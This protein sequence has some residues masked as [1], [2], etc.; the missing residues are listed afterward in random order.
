MR[1]VVISHV[2][3][4]PI[5]V[6]AERVG[7]AG[8]T[9]SLCYPFQGDPLPD[10]DSVSAVIVLGGAQSAY[11]LDRHP[12]LRDE[13]A[14]LAQAH[15]RQTPV[16]GICLGSQLL[17][18]AL[19]GR[20]L[21][22]IS[23]LEFGAISVD[24]TSEDN[25]PPGG[26]YYSFHSDTAQLPEDAEVLSVSDSYVQAW[27]S[28]SSSAIQFHPEIDFD[29]YDEILASEADKLERSGVDVAA[30]RSELAG[31]KQPSRHLSS[32]L[33]DT[34]LASLPSEPSRPA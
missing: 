15:E 21:P 28:G 13:I 31:P 3:A 5:P 25:W 8:H 20:A 19:G 9:I 17:A 18:E 30:L 27:R 16:L 6:L 26:T 1:I 32:Q 22:G 33:F 12:H 4:P 2:E 29:G 23:G 34:W 24:T 7:A 11:E 14:Y 10:L